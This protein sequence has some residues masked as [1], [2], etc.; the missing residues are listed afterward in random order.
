MRL[1]IDCGVYEIISFL[2]AHRVIVLSSVEPPN[3]KSLII[4]L[5]ANTP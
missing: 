5:K 2:W 1:P 3:K 4:E